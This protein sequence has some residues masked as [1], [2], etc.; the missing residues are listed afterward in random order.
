MYAD[1]SF[2]L[3]DECCRD[4]LR[5]FLLTTLGLESRK[6]QSEPNWPSSEF[7]SARA[8]CWCHLHFQSTTSRR[9]SLGCVCASQRAIK[10]NRRS[11]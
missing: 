8:S 7:K 5:V 10:E 11:T 9:G 2:H 4:S 3:A 1:Q 6:V